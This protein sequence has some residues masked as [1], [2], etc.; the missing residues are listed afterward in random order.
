M[1]SSD[2]WFGGR[3][4]GQRGVSETGRH[5]DRHDVH[6]EQFSSQISRAKPWRTW[7]DTFKVNQQPP[8]IRVR[9]EQH[10][11]K[12][13]SST[14]PC[15][16][17]NTRAPKKH[18]VHRHQTVLQTLGLFQI[19]SNPTFYAWKESSPKCFPD[20]NKRKKSKLAAKWTN[21]SS[22]GNTGEKNKTFVKHHNHAVIKMSKITKTVRERRI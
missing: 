13:N 1:K 22:W 12:C 8:S 11:R 21:K 17:W 5:D 19:K 4:A 2:A 7:P 15:Q 10:G 14:P 9:S 16:R 20:K 6:D 3:A 18:N